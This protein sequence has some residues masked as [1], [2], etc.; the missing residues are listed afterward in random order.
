LEPRKQGKR[1]PPDVEI[2]VI[3]AVLCLAAFAQGFLGFGFGI[4]AMGVLSLIGDPLHAAG[5]V[6]IAGLLQT[7]WLVIVLRRGV[8][9]KVA[10]RIVPGAA[11]GIVVGLLTLS[12]LSTPMLLRILGLTIL[13][14]S[15]WN[16]SRWR[17]SSDPSPAW[18][19]PVGFVSGGFTGL[20]NTG[21][22][23]I[24]AHIYRR[25][26]PPETLI[27][28][29]QVIFLFSALTRLPGAFSLGM[30]TPAVWHDAVLSL[31]FVLGG[32]WGGRRL[33]Q[34][35]DPERFRRVSWIALA[36]FG[37]WITWTA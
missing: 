33:G 32:V 28:T 13:A 17:P 7:T 24:I 35:L 27:G 11:A 22:P 19:T 1:Y 2:S 30:L 12:Q 31:V 16:L 5:V 25:P 34:R 10:L 37:V 21:G 3:A 23:P 36:L 18:D 8:L 4:I 29:V 15:M 14:F 26:D 9:W 20:F 6:N